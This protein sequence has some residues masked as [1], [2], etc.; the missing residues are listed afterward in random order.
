MQL[1]QTVYVHI[2]THS[3]NEWRFDYATHCSL[4]SPSFK[5]T[6]ALTHKQKH[7][8]K[9]KPQPRTYVL[10]SHRKLCGLHGMRI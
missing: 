6:A 10:R 1:V 8:V 3:S 2:H 5:P 9:H 7:T 4:Q